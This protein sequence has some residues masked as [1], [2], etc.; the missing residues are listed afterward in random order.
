MSIR[1]VLRIEKKKRVSAD[2]NITDAY[3]V[4][5]G[6]SNVGSALDGFR[7]PDYFNVIASSGSTS[8]TSNT[9]IYT[10]TKDCWLFIGGATN[11]TGRAAQV[12][13]KRGGITSGFVFNNGNSQKVFNFIPLKKGDIVVARGDA[14]D[15]LSY[16]YFVYDMESN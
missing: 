2:T 10:A 5:Y 8:Y 1:N 9:E 6:Q 3:K 14:T 7:R 15:T 12:Y 16:T 13:I 11:N 4:P